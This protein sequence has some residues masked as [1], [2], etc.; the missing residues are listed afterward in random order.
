MS[1]LAIQDEISRLLDMVNYTNH[2]DVNEQYLSQAMSL[3]Y[4][5]QDASVKSN[6]IDLI[7]R[8]RP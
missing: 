2:P 7:N 5:I 3:A 6:Y 8:S 4:Q 1:D